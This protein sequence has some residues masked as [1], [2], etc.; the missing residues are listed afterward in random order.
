MPD[1]RPCIRVKLKKQPHPA[2]RVGST[3]RR[4]YGLKGQSGNSSSV[5]LTAMRVR[6][7]TRKDRRGIMFLCVRAPKPPMW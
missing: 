4:V 1:E 5:E 3:H 7:R 6:Q 2:R